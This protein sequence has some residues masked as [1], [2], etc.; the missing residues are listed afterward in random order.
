KQYCYLN[1]GEKAV[2]ATAEAFAFGGNATIPGRPS[3]LEDMGR[4]LRFLKNLPPDGLDAPVDLVIVDT[5]GDIGAVLNLLARRNLMF[6]LSKKP[7]PGARVVQ[8]GD[9]ADPY[10]FALKVRREIGDEKRQL[11]V[12]GSE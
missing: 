2:L 6:R 4:M 7:V 9:A 8:K 5:G 11:K 1:V 12:Y 3:D 10:S